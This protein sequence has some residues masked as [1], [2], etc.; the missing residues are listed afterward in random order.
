MM[1]PSSHQPPELRQVGPSI[2]MSLNSSFLFSSISPIVG[3]NI[4]FACSVKLSS[5]SNY[6]DFGNSIILCLLVQFHSFNIFTAT[7]TDHGGEGWGGLTN[8]ETYNS[9]CSSHSFTYS[10]VNHQ[11]IKKSQ[12]LRNLMPDF[13]LKFNPDLDAKPKPGFVFD[14][15]LHQSQFHKN[16]K[17]LSK[18]KRQTKTKTKP[19]SIELSEDLGASHWL[20]LNNLNKSKPNHLFQAEPLSLTK[21]NI[22]YK[23]NTTMSQI[24]KAQHIYLGNNLR[25]L[26]INKGSSSIL[27]KIDILEHLVLSEEAQVVSIVESNVNLSKSDELKPMKGFNFEHKQLFINNVKSSIAR[28]TI[29]IKDNLPYTRMFNLENDQNSIIWLRIKINPKKYV[30][31]MSGYRQYTI[32]KEHKIKNSDKSECQ[33][34]RLKSYC[35]SITNALNLQENVIILD[36][37]NIDTNERVDYGLKYNSR[38]LYNYWKD[39][40]IANNLVIHNHEFTRYAPHQKPSIIDNITSNC[41]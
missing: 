12:C 6:N 2:S 35:Q 20:N 1:M 24:N 38:D 27:S 9:Y 5:A 19:L 39:M 33:L 37:T 32:L 40:I 34:E 16:L 13:Y 26:H 29:A 7:V 11:P 22:L 3:F 10:K 31:V 23:L 4:F 17:T 25:F 21:P 15:Y 28:T 41:P 18:S 8:T 30:L 36:D 14:S